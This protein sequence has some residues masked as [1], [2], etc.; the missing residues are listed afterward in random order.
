MLHAMTNRAGG[1]EYDGIE[2]GGLPVKYAGFDCGP[3]VLK[4]RS[5]A[6]VSQ[7]ENKAQRLV[8]GLHL[9]CVDHALASL[10][11]HVGLDDAWC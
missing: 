1:K 8:N 4:V 5:P 9:V 11:F 2:Y 10:P 6:R 3:M 7:I